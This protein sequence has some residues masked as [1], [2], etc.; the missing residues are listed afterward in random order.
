M[1]RPRMP[2]HTST[3]LIS[4]DA[5]VNVRVEKTVH[6][7]DGLG[8]VHNQACFVRGALPGELVRV[9]ITAR[10]RD[11][12]RAVA[13]DILEPSPGRRSPACPVFGHCGGC[14]WQHAAYD[15]QIEMKKAILEEAFRRIGGFTDV[16]VSPLHPAPA[17]F[18]YRSRLRAQVLRT[19]NTPMIGFF[20]CASHDVVPVQACMLA[21]PGINDA[22]AAFSAAAAHD[23][24]LLRGAESVEALYSCHEQAVLLMC[25][26]RS[27]T[28]HTR[29]RHDCRT[30][31]LLADR[32]SSLIELC[33]GLQFLHSGTAFTQVNHAQNQYM[34]DTVM[35]ALQPGPG[36]KI[37][38]LFCGSG[39][40]SL[41]L[42]HAGASVTGIEAHTAAVA[43]ARRNA[44]LNDVAGCR[45]VCADANTADFTRFGTR[46]DVV[47]LNPPRAGC[48]QNL[49]QRLCRGGAQRLV[50]VS[51]NPTTLARDYAVLRAGGYAIAQILPL[52]MF[53]QTSHLETICILDRSAL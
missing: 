30:R 31:E 47:I 34:I 2:H 35:D 13:G 49:L 40:F 44:R 32:S 52:D 16:P 4:P 18:N 37:L 51:C 7:G 29:L 33:G 9:R 23:P 5:L 6:G 1:S 25:F 8:W 48:G 27:R 24:A 43:L 21:V 39:N 45:F 36:I 22:L 46:W 38:D 42:A 11:Y 15:L 28:L 14:Q 17:E 50:Y 19:G 53:P 12:V 3:P 41:M 20:R 10:K 26:N